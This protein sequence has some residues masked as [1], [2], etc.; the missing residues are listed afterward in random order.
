MRLKA[1]FFCDD[2]RHEVGN[3]ISA[4]G[5]Y[6]DAIVFPPGTGAFGLPKLAAV[7]IVA[8]LAG[9]SDLRLK[10]ALIFNGKANALP[11]VVAHRDPTAD[12]QNF[13]FQ[14]MPAVFPADGVL[15]ARVELFAPERHAQFECKVS[16][17]RG[18]SGL[19]VS[20]PTTPSVSN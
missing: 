5:I 12:E 19:A 13:V 11:E 7:F 6:N 10:Q 18:T 16:I 14:Q 8:G 4:V 17:R 20:V 2:I 9:V 1:A 15:T 3:K